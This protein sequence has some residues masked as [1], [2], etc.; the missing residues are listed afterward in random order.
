MDKFKMR[1]NN[2][3][4]LR[5]IFNNDEINNIELEKIFKLNKHKDIL[6]DR[7]INNMDYSKIAKKYYYSE[8]TIYRYISDALNK[9]SEH[10]GKGVVNMPKY[11]IIG[12]L[13]DMTTDDWRELR[14]G[15]I[16]GSDSAVTM[17]LNPYKTQIELFYEKIGY[18]IDEFKGN[19][20]TKVGNLLEELVAEIFI[21]K[22][23][24]KLIEDTNIYQ[25]NEYPFMLANLDY[26]VEDYNGNRALL[27]CKTSS[28]YRGEIWKKSIPIEYEIQCRHYMAVMDI[29][30]CYIACLFDNNENSFVYHTIKRDLEIEQNII[31]NEKYF[32]EYHVQ[33]CIEPVFDS[34]SVEANK[35]FINK[36][37]KHNKDETV[38][39]DNENIEIV[40]GYLDIKKQR[41]DMEKELKKSITMF[42]DMEEQCKL[43]LLQSMEGAEIGTLAGFQ[44]TNKVSISYTINK[45]NLNKLKLEFP[46]VYEK[47]ATQSTRKTFSV[48]K[49]KEK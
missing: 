26:M 21:E 7:F 33:N 30:V 17:N 42:K 35:E 47:Y 25:S 18:P 15:Y 49:V 34:S 6:I 40:Q 12:N 2:S 44:I 38:V 16:G 13:K 1:K 48:K 45:D 41:E 24:F 37:Y 8:R 43:E 46:K 31:E 27:E 19:I 22:T 5:K 20:A 29:D 32:W 4:K 3:E 36:F 14:K 10:D 39:L 23:G 9:L 11:K 28:Y